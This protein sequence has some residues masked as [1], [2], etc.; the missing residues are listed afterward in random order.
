[1]EARERKRQV[2][3][4]GASPLVTF[5]YDAANRV[6]TRAYRNGIRAIYAYDAND[7]LTRV[8][9]RLGTTSLVRTDHG[10]DRE[11]NK[12]FERKRHEP[13]GSQ[14]SP[15]GSEAYEYDGVYRLV[16]YKVGTLVGSIVPSP[17]TQSSYDL[18]LLGNWNSKTTDG[19]TEARTHNEVNEIAA[20]ETQP[21]VH[22]D[23][24]N[25]VDD[26]D[27]SYDYDEENR[28]V[29]V[30]RK[31]PVEVLGEYQ[32]DAL[33]RRVRKQDNFGQE[34]LY[35]YDGQRI[36]EEQDG[37]GV[38]RATYVFGNY[39]DEVLTMDRGGGT[40]YYHQNALLSVYALSNSSGVLVEGYRYDVYG[41]QTVFAPG[42]NGVINFGGDDVAFVGGASSLRNPFT[43]TGREFD[44]DT[45]LMHYRA[46]TYDPVQGRFKQRDPLGHVD[47]MNLYEY[48]SGAPTRWLDPSGLKRTAAQC[49]DLNA[50]WH[51]FCET[52]KGKASHDACVNCW[53]K[54][55]TLCASEAF[56]ENYQ[57]GDYD[58]AMVRV[59]RDMTGTKVAPA[60]GQAA[61][62]AVKLAGGRD[63]G[64]TGA[65]GAG[66][67][68]AA[69]KY[70]TGAGKDDPP[71]P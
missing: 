67:A 30:T 69:Y 33:G 43:Y 39:L 68:T 61:R 59:K 21:L 55:V 11:G 17:V 23:N 47:G 50:S 16:T 57:P 12:L 10:Y 36:V 31:V 28:L 70:V 20:I 65:A 7:L 54:Y 19:V 9:H 14:A 38:T 41:R 8:D 2:D 66:A 63:P 25:L 3:D 45:G 60:L 15:G 24:G 52:H 4:G 35:F 46:R 34:T 1:M 62:V 32:Y 48:V 51:T 6:R 18:D 58:E 26:G 40:Y 13:T 64:A 29:R 37:S 49:L 53:H 71:E 27:R 56:D 5:T 42:A 22:D 44:S